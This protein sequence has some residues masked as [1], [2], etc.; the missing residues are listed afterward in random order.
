[1]YFLF[2]SK[3]PFIR[4]WS[5]KYLANKMKVLWKFRYTSIS[6]HSLLCTWYP[7]ACETQIHLIR[8]KSAFFGD[9]QSKPFFSA[10]F[11]FRYRIGSIIPHSRNLW[12]SLGI[13]CRSYLLNS[14]IHWHNFSDF[15]RRVFVCFGAS[16]SAEVH[17]FTC[18][19]FYGVYQYICA[20]LMMQKKIPFSLKATPKTTN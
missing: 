10:I 1:M 19:L 20:S 17:C 4:E 5:D 11:L 15:H 16:S 7:W 3:Y 9:L 2:L 12:S 14:R 6:L 13:N 18:F 8:L